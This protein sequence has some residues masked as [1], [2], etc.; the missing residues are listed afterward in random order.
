[1][2]LYIL[3]DGVSIETEP[4]KIKFNLPNSE[5]IKVDSDVFL[6]MVPKINEKVGEIILHTDIAEY[7]T[8][9]LTVTVARLASNATPILIFKRDEDSFQI[10]LGDWVE[11]IN[12]IPSI[13]RNVQ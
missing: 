10:T 4:R 1:M 5:Y 12:S 7:E 6:K 13:R 3:G 2:V 9:E 11:I 8:N